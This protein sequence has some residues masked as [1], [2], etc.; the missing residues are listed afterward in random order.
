MKRSVPMVVTPVAGMFLGLLLLAGLAGLAG[1]SDRDIT[2][3]PTA[4]G[5]TDPLVF[6]DA[7]GPDVYFQ[8]FYQT[9][10]TASS[11]D[12]VFAY[13]GYQF[14]GA[15]SLKFE[16]PPANSALGLYLGGVLTSAGARDLSGYNALTFYAR[17]DGNATLDVAGFGNDNTGNSLYEAGR[18]NIALTRD[19]TFVVVPIPDPSK[20]IS[21]RGLFTLAEATEEAQPDGY[22]I[23]FDE[24]RFANLGNIEVFRPIMTSANKDYFIGGTVSISGTRTIFLVDG[25]YVPVDHSANYF[26]YTSSDEEVAVYDGRDIR[27]VGPGEATI[28]AAL[29]TN[30]VF[31]LINVTGYEPP[32]TGAPA[33]T[34]SAGEVVSLY[35][36]AYANQLIDTWRADWGGV[37]TQF[38]EFEVHGDAALMYTTLNWVGVLFESRY[39][40]ALGMDYFHLDLYAP[41]GEDFGIELVSFATGAGDGSTK[42]V[43]DAA[44]DPAFAAGE[45]MSIDIP[46]SEFVF[47]EGNDN[48]LSALG[49]MVF[50]SS[51][52]GLV[53]VDNVYFHN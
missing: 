15:R 53:L 30:E 37:T 21:E 47:D 27:I 50:S 3:L 1:C 46:V 13:G 48:A 49:Q 52:A 45:W 25:G 19:W 12:S 23:W 7:Y 36:D 11:I 34:H 32:T 26:D 22:N 20:L 18:G 35:S 10:Y 17:T 8:P 41:E 31:G 5:N 38:E 33:P 29:D 42:V 14:D 4:E 2:D 24:I 40:D 28:T 16:V 51:T 43:I 9:H 44:S 6:D 39:I